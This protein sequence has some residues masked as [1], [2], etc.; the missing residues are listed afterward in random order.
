MTESGLTFAQVQET[1][2]D[3]FCIIE[4]ED[5]GPFRSW[6]Y[7]DGEVWLVHRDHLRVYSMRLAWHGEVPEAGWHHSPGCDCRYCVGE[8]HVTRAGPDR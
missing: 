4:S 5:A 6:L 2:R 7:E 1:A 8:R 3:A